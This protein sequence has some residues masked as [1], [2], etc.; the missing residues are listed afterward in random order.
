MIQRKRI[1][2]GFTLVELLVVIAII[3]ILIALLLPAVQAAREAARRSQCTNNLKQYGLALHNYHDVYKTFPRTAYACANAACASG[4]GCTSW[5]KGYSVHSML[6]PFIEQNAVYD[7]FDWGEPAVDNPNYA[8]CRATRINPFMCPS[9]SPYPDTSYLGNTN[10]A[11][12]LGA[13][14]GNTGNAVEQNGMFRRD[15]ETAM[16]DVRD[17]TSNTIMA[18]EILIGDGTGNTYTVGDVVYSVA[19]VG[20]IQKPTQTDLETYGASC[21]ASKANH[22]SHGGRAWIDCRSF[23]TTFTAI[24][25]PNW[26]WPDCTSDRWDAG[27]TLRAARSQ[28][29]GGANHSL[30]DASVRFISET[31]NFDTYQAL[32]TREGKEPISDF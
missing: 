24:A 28:H 14:W 26:K 21:E 20:P 18:G 29:P 19:R 3:G 6:L 11:V 4:S 7:Q 2:G 13:C 22:H 9:D 16:R 25:P 17:G 23:E 32:G 8:L 15:W 10:Y 31:V 5:W 27:P 12:C 1:L 30:G